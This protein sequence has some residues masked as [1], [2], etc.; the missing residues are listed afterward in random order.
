MLL[1]LENFAKVNKYMFLAK[2]FQHNKDISK[3]KEQVKAKL[4]IKYFHS[5]G[6]EI[7]TT[8]GPIDNQQFT[9]KVMSALTSFHRIDLQ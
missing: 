8:S 1:L 5:D 4:K 6:V 3:P 9:I 2:S 7:H